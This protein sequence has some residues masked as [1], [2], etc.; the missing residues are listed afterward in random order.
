MD[1]VGG[2]GTGQVDLQGVGAD[3]YGRWLDVGAAH[4]DFDIGRFSGEGKAQQVEARVGGIG[5]GEQGVGEAG[6]LVG[7]G[8][9]GGD[10]ALGAL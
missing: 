10:S 7:L 4:A 1:G 3:G 8:D 5:C 9:S 6:V 2:D